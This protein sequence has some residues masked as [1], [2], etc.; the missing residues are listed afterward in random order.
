MHQCRLSATTVTQ[1]YPGATGATTSDHNPTIARGTEDIIYFT[2]LTNQSLILL[3][4]TST[5]LDYLF[6]IYIF[7][8]LI[9]IIG[10]Q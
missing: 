7:V 6:L 10:E 5:S 3:Y 9:E 1:R 2:V 8:N 4:E